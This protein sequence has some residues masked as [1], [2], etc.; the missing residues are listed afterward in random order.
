MN[1]FAR[2]ALSNH[3]LARPFGINVGVVIRKRR[4]LRR[5]VQALSVKRAAEPKT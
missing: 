3:T 5:T 2:F 4:D 1:R